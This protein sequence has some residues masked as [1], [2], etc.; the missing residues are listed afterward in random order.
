MSEFVWFLTGINVIAT[1]GNIYIFYDLMRQK[2][3]L[4]EEWEAMRRSRES[5]YRSFPKT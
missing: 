5:G 2:D 3:Y 1:I 4:R